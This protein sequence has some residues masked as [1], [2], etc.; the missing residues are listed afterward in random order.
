MAQQQE[1]QAPKLKTYEIFHL[2]SNDGFNDRYYSGMIEA[3]NI[4]Q[5][6][7]GI[8]K[9]LEQNG[10][11]GDIVEVD[12]D[13]N[14]LDHETAIIQLDTD[15]TDENGNDLT[16]KEVYELEQKNDCEISDLIE[17]G[18]LGYLDHHYEIIEVDSEN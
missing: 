3:T 17:D 12:F 2:E 4:D 6:I 18:K 10:Y 16:M 8:K 5:A 1:Q 11:T 14:S 9:N 13:T 7:E 15:Y